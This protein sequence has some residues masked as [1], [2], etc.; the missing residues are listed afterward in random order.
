MQDRRLSNSNDIISINCF[1]RMNNSGSYYFPAYPPI[2]AIM[3]RPRNLFGSLC[4]KDWHPG[5]LGYACSR[6]SRACGVL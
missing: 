5:V 3:I 2:C 4:C 6:G 1:G